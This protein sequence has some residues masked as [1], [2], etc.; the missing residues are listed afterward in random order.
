MKS[1]VLIKQVREAPSISGEPGGEG[2]VGTD[3]QNV[4][5]PYDQYAIEEALQGREK[6]G[7]EVVA[8]TLGPDSAVESLREALAM[9]VNGAVH[10]NDPAFADLDAPAAAKVLAAAVKRIGDVDL[11]IV[12]KVTIDMNTQLTG[13][14]VARHLGASLVTEV[15]EVNGVDLE[16]RTVTAT[17]ALEGGQQVVKAKLPAVLAVVKDINQPRYASLLGIRKAAKSPIT[18]WSA[19]D[20]GVEASAGTA[21]VAR[22]LPPARPAGEIFQGEPDE[23]V[24]KLVDR[25][26]GAK[27]I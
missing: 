6:N 14:M 21:V 10:L 9:G 15:C 4:T 1:I 18:V 7:G 13:P 22:H 23:I 24:G 5:N 3:S 8:V 26:A 27:F 12:G 16:G 2:T 25:L 17:R 20:L 19:S 11:V